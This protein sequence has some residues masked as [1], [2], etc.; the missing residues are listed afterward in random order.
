MVAIIKF[1]V[2]SVFVALAASPVHPEV[3]CGV[4]VELREGWSANVLREDSVECE[5][6]IRPDEWNSIVE[7]ARWDEGEHAIHL[8]VLRTG[9]DEAG[10]RM[11]FTF[12]LWGDDWRWGTMDRGGMADAEPVQYGPFAGWLSDGWFRGFA[13]EGAVF[14][15]QSRLY[16]G[17]WRVVLLKL[18]DNL[19]FGLQYSRWNPDIDLDRDS[20]AD[21]ILTNLTVGP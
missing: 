3:L 13:K 17:T 18:S 7:K 20:V 6:G 14:E 5:I 15:D 8:K 4:C 19:S 16:S 21:Q 10:S 2:G 11:G 12:E 9:F 1:L